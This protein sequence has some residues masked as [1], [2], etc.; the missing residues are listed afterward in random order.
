MNQGGEPAAR[1]YRYDVQALRGLAVLLVV[2]FHAGLPVHGGFVGVDVFFV[3]SGFVIGTLI[4]AELGSTS[5]LRFRSFYTRRARRLL[6][7]L[8]VM[9]GVVVITAPLLAP[10][11]AKPYTTP[12][13]IAASLFSANI[14]L[15]RLQGGYFAPAVDLNPL[16]HTWSLSVE[17]Q[18]YFVIPALL[19][20]A[21]RIG[22]R[23]RR[24]LLVLQVFVALLFASSLAACLLFSNGGGIGPLNG[25]KF[26]FF[27]PVTRAWE[28]AAGL[29]LVFVPGGFVRRLRPVAV[30]VGLGLIGFAA[31]RFSGTTVFPG[32]AA[33]V[34]VAGAALVI[35]GGTRSIDDARPP[36]NPRALRPFTWMG[37][38][39][40]SWYLWHWPLIVY[41]GAFWPNAGSLP[42]AV[43]AVVSLL[44]AWLSYRWLEQRF[45][46]RAGQTIGR[47][48]VLVACC[49]ATPLLLAGL[50]KPI[51]SEVHHRTT[52]RAFDAATSEHTGRGPCHSSVPLDQRDPNQC[53]WGARSGPLDVQ[54]VGD[55]NAAHFNE[56]MIGATARD[57]ASLRITTMSDC[58]FLDLTG[59]AA[60]S[61]LQTGPCA[62]FVA[63]TLDELERHPPKVVV[64][65]GD[66][67]FGAS[68]R[69]NAQRDPRQALT[70][71]QRARA[72]A[73]EAGLARSARRLV[74]AGSKVVIIHVVPKPEDWDPRNCSS[75]LVLTDVD[76]CWGGS[77]TLGAELDLHASNQ[78]E[79]KAAAAAGATVWD[80]APE[81]CPDARCTFL[82][83]KDLVWLNDQHISVAMSKKLIPAMAADL[84]AVLD[85]T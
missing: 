24:P 17:E 23:A 64:I 27:S 11:G 45:R 68:D 46:L 55:S 51:A 59:T 69:A 42:L 2:L 26:A 66:T 10:I 85:G 29:A 79:D 31:F 14:Y 40:Y 48:P 13:A 16:L 32:A 49:I 81:I 71:S 72:D 4:V 3:I 61:G 30:V 7:A 56:A 54:V 53:R 15:Y 75:L 44:P 82:Q 1:R 58:Q 60:P 39:S 43:A 83:G 6:P 78:V 50:S 34:P 36:A 76:R 37:D 35:F 57:D 84:K 9:L 80:F 38:L 52:V 21:W 41:A 65:A 77:F 74:A 73:T 62:A 47:T 18:F 12:T 8:A 20:V 33:M 25:V 67:R 70:P 63:G 22:T 5:A 28:F 19:A